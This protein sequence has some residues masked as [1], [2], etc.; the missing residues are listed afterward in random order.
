MIIRTVMAKSSDARGP[1]ASLSRLGGLEQV[2]DGMD[3]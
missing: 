2:L 1:Y 3:R